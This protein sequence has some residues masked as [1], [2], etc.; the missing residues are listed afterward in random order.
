MAECT[1]LLNEGASTEEQDQFG[2]TPLILASASGNTKI[3]SLLLDR[4]ANIQAI[5]M[6]GGTPLHNAKNR[7]MTW[8]LLAHGAALE[9]RDDFGRTPLHWATSASGCV[10][11]LLDWGAEIEAEDDEGY[12][13]LWHAIDGEKHESAVTLILRGASV[14]LMRSGTIGRQVY[15]NDFD[16]FLV[17]LRMI[18]SG[19]GLKSALKRRRPDVLAAL[20]EHQTANDDFIK[21]WEKNK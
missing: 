10:D 7:E 12:T 14:G 1:S 15:K 17:L 16:I 3:A 20:S 8:T 19:S 6:D 21:I 5:G 13:P 18:Q 4:G 11:M 9:T 2:S